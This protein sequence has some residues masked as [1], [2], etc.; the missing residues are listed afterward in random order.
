MKS[1]KRIQEKAKL[2]TID[3][4]G[5]AEI[6]DTPRVYSDKNLSASVLHLKIH[7]NFPQV[8]GNL[9]IDTAFNIYCCASSY[10][11]LRFLIRFG[12][13]SAELCFWCCQMSGMIR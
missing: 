11:R 13:L 4:V 12:Q 2:E 9:E 1:L 6:D 3:E 10:R 5:P 7:L 8:R